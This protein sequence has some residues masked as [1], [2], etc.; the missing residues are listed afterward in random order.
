MQDAQIMQDLSFNLEGKPL[1]NV[2]KA[3][4]F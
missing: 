3:P 2:A 4:M 1:I